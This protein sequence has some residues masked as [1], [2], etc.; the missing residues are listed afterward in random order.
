MSGTAEASIGSDRANIA[1]IEQ[2]ISAQG[3]R[4]QALVT[5]YNEAQAHLSELNAQIASDQ[6]LV[7]TNRGIEADAASAM[8][9]VAV[10][11]YTSGSELDSPTIAMV[12]GTW[13][14]I[15]SAEQNQYLGAVNGKLDAKVATLRLAR[16]RA[17]D[18]ERNLESEQAQARATVRELAAARD[19]ASAAI[20]S[21]EAQLTSVKGDLGS[22]IAADSARR[23]ADQLAAERALAAATPLRL[24]RRRLPRRSRHRRRPRRLPRPPVTRIHSVRS[25]HSH[26]SESTKASTSAASDRSMRSATAW[27]STP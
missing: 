13:S 3:A 8:R 4:A 9:R 6:R 19:A 2:E 14:V 21:E 18:A 17:Q 7:A 12:T 10:E 1:R 27:C 25:R 20:A 16:A 15:T 26:P 11:A 22:L 24:S 5:R 23:R